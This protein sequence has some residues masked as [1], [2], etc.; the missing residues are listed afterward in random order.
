MGLSVKVISSSHMMVVPNHPLRP[1]AL[2]PILPHPLPPMP[3]CLQFNIKPEK[4]IALLRAAGLLPDGPKSIAEFLRSPGLNKVPCARNG[5]P[6]LT[7]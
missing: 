6:A 7:H 5:G 4:G 2:H 1:P 3:A